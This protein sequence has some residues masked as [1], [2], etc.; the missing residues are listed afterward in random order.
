MKDSDK[1]GICVGIVIYNNGKNYYVRLRYDDNDL[2][3]DE[4]KQ[5]QVP[6][7]REPTVN[8]LE[9]RPYD[10]PFEMYHSSGFT[11]LEHFIAAYL[12]AKDEGGTTQQ[13]IRDNIKVGVL[14][15]RTDDYKKDEFLSGAGEFLGFFVVLCYLPPIFK[16]VT[17]LVQDKELKTREGMNMMGLKDSAYWLSFLVYYL[18]ILAVLA[19]LLA[20][21][22][23]IFIFTHSNWF[24]TFLYYYLYGISIFS[25]GFCISTLF[26]RTR[27]ACITATMLYFAAYLISDLVNDE[28]MGETAKN[29]ASLLPPVAADLGST[30]FAN[31]EVG[32]SGVNFGNARRVVENYRFSTCLIMFVVDTLIYGIIG[33][34]L[35]NVLPN[36]NGVRKPIYFFLTKEFWTGSYGE[37]VEPGAGEEESEE[38]VLYPDDH[39]ERVGEDL[40]AQEASNECLSIRHL[41]KYFGE[42]TA[43][44]N[45]SVNMYR[46]QIFALL[47]P[48]GAGKT[49][50]LSMLCGL[51]PVSTGNASFAGMA[52]FRDMVKVR[53]K[54]GVCPQHDVLF[55]SLS[56]KEHLQVFA[57]F[58]GRTDSE[59]VSKDVDEILQDIELK[60]CE[61]MLACN[62]SG[63]QRRKLSIGIAFVGN[64]DMIFLDEPTSGIDLATRKRVWAMLK[65]YKDKKVIILTTHYMEEAE[66]LGDRIG[67]M[68]SGKL[69]CVGSPLFLKSIYGAGYNLLISHEKTTE[70]QQVHDNITAFV[71]NFIE[72][73][74]IRKEAEKEITYFLPKSQSTKFKEFFLE[75]DKSLG[76]LK[77]ESYGMATNT[78]EEIFLRVAREDDKERGQ[79]LNA[80]MYSM[81]MSK[82]V[83]Q[84]TEDKALDTYS[85]ANEAELPFFEKFTLHSSA[86]LK[87][88][89]IINFRNIGTIINEILVPIILVTFGFALTKISTFS[90]S[91]ARE[92]SIWAYSTPHSIVVNDRT[93]DG[94]AYTEFTNFFMQQMEPKTSSLSLSSNDND[95][96]NLEKFDNV[97]FEA[98]RDGVERYGSLYLN[99]ID[100][101]TN[102][103]EYVVLGNMASQESA[104][105]YV[106][107]FSQTL[108]RAI[109]NDND[110]TLTYTTAPFPLTE[111]ARNLEQAVKGSIVSN[112]LVI[113]F[114]LVPA[115]IISFI[116]QERE[117]SL[118]HQQ[119]IS[120]VSLAAYWLSNGVIDIFKSLIPCSFS[121]A[122]I[123]AFDVDLTYGWLFVLVY[124]FSI[125]PFTYAMSFLFNKENVAQTSI[126]LFNFF[127][128]VVL[129]PVFNILRVFDNTRTA[130][131][132]LAW[133][134]RF[135]PSFCLSYGIN[136]ISFRNLYAALERKEVKPY[137]NLSVAGAD[138]LFLCIDF[139]LYFILICLTEAQ[140]FNFLILCCE[141]KIVESAAKSYKDE[142]VISEEKAC[143]SMPLDKDPPAVLTR[144]LKKVY[145]ISKKETIHAVRD[146]SFYVKKGECL[147]FLGTAGAG[148]TTTFKLVTHDLLPTQG[149]VFIGGL[150]LEH[151]FPRI[152]RMFGYGPQ[153]ESAYFSM[154]VRENLEYYSKIKGIPENLREPMI[155]KLINE[156]D[157][158]RYEHVQVGQLSGGNKR[159]TTVA[160]AL[161]GN[162]P[163]VLLD[164]PSTGVDPQA[165]RFMWHI[166]QRISTKNKNTAVLLTTHSME[167]AEYLCTKM[168]I[169]I[170][171][172]FNC[173]GAPQELKDKYG[174]G[175]EIQISLPH[176]K[177]EDE[178]KYLAKYGIQLDTQLNMEE[179]KRVFGA[180]GKP[181]LEEEL[182][183]KGNAAHIGDELRNKEVVNA[184]VLASFMILE[185]Q[186][187]D[188]GKLLANEFGEVRVP[189]HIGNF[190]KFKVDKTKPSHT[191][192][193]L[194]G[195][196][197]DVVTKYNITQYSASQTSLNQIFQSLVKQSESGE[198]IGKEGRVIRAGD[199]HKPLVKVEGPKE[200]YGSEAYLAVDVS[201]I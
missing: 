156:M 154:T 131:K 97:V 75:L 48:N 63:G 106:G 111:K 59:S 100:R 31:Y 132:A 198:E 196:L 17:M 14:A 4:D 84:S 46:S 66:E 109:K 39:F 201:K 135:F 21:I 53:E 32:R 181:E 158:I 129:S 177:P 124:S 95:Q 141:P 136:N 68:T 11:Y 161:L 50:T 22:V 52:I 82:S 188:I 27:T 28:T 43:V 162:P 116:V 173:I 199:E 1:P 33:L 78:M 159:K 178:E 191:I 35:D 139:V 108:L 40:K 90:N 115:G 128:G 192:G 25:F 130:G 101:S 103:Y 2:I 134:L 175:F 171:G 93:P 67:I 197:Q 183:N 49:T 160:I 8:D 184:K 73:V 193:F 56:P 37:K 26:V 71:K 121:I 133:I 155:V 16:I 145:A 186:F 44:S 36:A 91:D 174:K 120:G 6:N 88:R 102:T 167:E 144:H 60:D 165:K 65:K 149:E 87:K 117:G 137:L 38:N 105:A 70:I 127:V 147:A 9:K 5:Q 142:F 112:T 51:L 118:K 13:Q 57:A 113:A 146:L 85:I 47:G 123:Y 29:A 7:T 185:E 58:K 180:A 138:L 42:K 125:I 140:C 119:L 92:F 194:F 104:A 3:N 62:L 34:Y 69:R 15:M 19:V 110:Y 83:A 45:F 99:K 151:N 150:E 176:P 96:S 168:A 164:E 77:I 98:A 182:G 61:S 74:H 152:R 89:W 10:E 200:A 23:V 190:F 24:I 72:G 166:I 122:M 30:S 179:V 107:Y 163:I 153:Y 157:L 195:M 41:N 94:T 148:K 187:L 172:E 64:C 170:G 86:I 18:I 81:S 76:S 143:D 79:K 20:T 169:M 55:E 12:A 126:L 189:E 80:N 114:A 54:L